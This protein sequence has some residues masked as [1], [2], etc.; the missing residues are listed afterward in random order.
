MKKKQMITLICIGFL[1]LLVSANAWAQRPAE[2]QGRLQARAVLNPSGGNPSDPEQEAAEEMNR[3]LRS[4]VI[5]Q[6][7]FG[8]DPE[9]LRPI[10]NETYDE[11]LELL[12]LKHTLVVELRE[13]LNEPNPAPGQVGQLIIDIRELTAEIKVISQSWGD[14]IERLLNGE[15][16][17]KLAMVRRVAGLIP[18]FKQVGLI[19]PPPPRVRPEEE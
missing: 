13:L 5:V 11:M 12:R 14:E 7:F 9:A 19:P 8:I 1:V 18:A 2:P 3:I 17:D 4:L 16:A 10:V 15:Q 6:K